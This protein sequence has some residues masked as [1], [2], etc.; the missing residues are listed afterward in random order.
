M[1]RTLSMASLAL[2]LS[3]LPAAFALSLPDVLLELHQRTAVL[4]ALGEREDAVTNLRRVQRDPLALR[5]D[6]LQAEQ[7]LSLARATLTQT[8]YTTMRELTD[9]YTGVLGAEAG[10][11]LAQDALTLSGRALEIA[12]IRFESGSITQ[13]DLSDAQAAVTEAE[14]SVQAALEGRELA[15]NTLGSL[16]GQEVEPGTLQEIPAAF[17]TEV[18][19]LEAALAN[20]TGHPDLLGTVQQAELARFA[21]EVLDPLYAPQTEIESAT[22]NLQTA[23][24]GVREAKRGFSLQVR[25]LH[26]QAENART[27]LALRTHDLEAA[28]ERLVVQRQ[29]LAGGLIS[30]LAFEQAELE[31]QQTASETENARTAY[32]SALLELQAGSLTPLPGPYAAA[33]NAAALNPVP[34]NPAD[35]ARSRE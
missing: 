10:L 11:T 6:I 29:R 31:T 30:R 22:R 32:L 14:S 12:T 23:R 21:T 26:S 5:S 33:L 8:R 2:V 35:H 18:P 27:T 19:S 25:A 3:V 24:T 4:N 17:L 13:Q 28:R 1:K 15:L 34:P 20:A 16:L 9:A 7:R